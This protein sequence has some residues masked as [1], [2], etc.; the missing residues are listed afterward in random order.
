MHSFKQLEENLKHQIFKEKRKEE[1]ANLRE[2]LDHQRKKK[3]KG[4]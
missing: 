4:R 2:I 3:C 1:T